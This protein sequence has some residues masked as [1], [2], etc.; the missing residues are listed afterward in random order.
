MNFRIIGLVLIF[1]SNNIFSQ[2]TFYNID[3]VREIKFNFDQPNWKYLLDSLYV[4]GNEQ[5]IIGTVTI[6]GYQYDS[7]GIRYKGYSS[8]N[9][10]QTKNPFNI[11]LDYI[12]N[13][14]E[15]Q[16]FNKIKLSN[17]IHDPSFLREALSYQIARKY[18]PSSKANFANLYINDT[19]WGV[20]SNVEAVNKDFLSKHYQSR[21]NSFF[22][23]NPSSLD[24]FGENSN[25]SLSPGNDSLDY[26]A[27]YS[28]KS[29]YGW[30]KLHQL[31]DTLNNYPFSIN[32]ILNVDRTLWMHAFNYSLVNLDSY[33]G[34]AQNYYLYE[35]NSGRFNPILWDLNMSF[36]SF[37]LTD[38]SSYFSGMNIS[39]AKTLDPLSH[40]YNVSVFPRPLMRN[41]FN[42]NRFRKMYMAHLKTIM[43]ENFSNL[44]YLDSANK[45]HQIIDQS[46]NLDSNK[47]YSYLDFQ[48]NIDSTV[49]NTIN[50]PGIKDLMS[51][52]M[53]YLSNYSGYNHN[54][55]ID[56]I[57]EYN[58]TLSIGDNLWITANIIDADQVVLFY[59]FKSSGAFQET[60]MLDNGNNNDGAIGDF[61]YG[62]KI[63]N[64]GNNTQYFIYAEND[65]AGQFSPE[66]AAY[67]F[68]EYYAPIQAGDLVI[69]E[70]LAINDN[71]VQ[72]EF[73]DYA[74]WIEL[75]NNTN[76]S[77]ST[78]ELFLTDDSTNLL[79][80][81]IP[82]INIPA[83][84][85]LILWADEKHN[86]GIKHT[87]FKLANG[88][89]KLILSNNSGQIIDYLNFPTQSTNV[90]YA[91]IPNGIG[92][93]VYNTPSFGYDNDFAN[94]SSINQSKLSCYPNPFK[95]HLNILLEN[96][97]ETLISICDIQGKIILQQK[98]KPMD[99]KLILNTSSFK[100]G[101]YFVY[102]NS[103]KINSIQKII[104]D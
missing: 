82:D 39:Q 84:G 22:K 93:F 28:I 7:V 51:N 61:I 14:Q 46:V 78:Y 95:N 45:M 76:S 80:W 89:E 65:S 97:N 47:F 11:K 10:T 54:I 83:N 87:N 70:I 31:I 34:Y 96:P 27:F 33:I 19:L 94:V 21:N 49:T 41:I 103:S 92:N 4:L 16:G 52:R 8:V 53:N 57:K 13:D 102:L 17:V 88:G 55:T 66:R 12:I 91:R 77:L 37:R 25:L 3:T 2:S 40:L 9:I 43:E 50:Y 56:S 48:N 32:K 79:K 63:P 24:L 67:E 69:N 5:R 1:L 6:D 36:G 74:D 85:Y 30:G 38:A 90:G 86:E 98:V 15:H 71:V 62:A 100:K 59:R 35:D 23:C 42:D 18:M 75:Y 101:M 44:S 26:E 64:I 81:N 99:H 104:K 58:N 72:N 68:Y 20:Y 60:L 29:D 73:G